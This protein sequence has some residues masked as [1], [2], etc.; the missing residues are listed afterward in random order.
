VG[1]RGSRVG[2]RQNTHIAPV[3]PERA[4]SEGPRSTAAVGATW[5]LYRNETVQKKGEGKRPGALLAR[6]TR[7]IRMWSS[8][9]RSRGQPRPLPPILMLGRRTG[10]KITEGAWLAAAWQRNLF[11]SKTSLNGTWDIAATCL[12]Q[13]ASARLRRIPQGHDARSSSQSVTSQKI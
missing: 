8:D 12:W 5:V 6:R 10:G 13:A 9:A 2:E 11:H 7:T 4:P 1:E 3:L